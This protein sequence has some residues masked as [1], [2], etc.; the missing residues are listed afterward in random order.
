MSE[1]S[2]PYRFVSANN[3]IEIYIIIITNTAF[4][5]ARIMTASVFL[6]VSEK[7]HTGFQW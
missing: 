5:D 6:K 4:T 3:K 2:L 1:S 7:V